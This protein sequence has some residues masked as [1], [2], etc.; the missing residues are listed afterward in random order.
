M[1]RKHKTVNRAKYQRTG[2][3]KEAA[4]RGKDD[5]YSEKQWQHRLRCQN[6]SI[7]SWSAVHS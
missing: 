5:A 2:I 6:W 7:A 3:E 4:D 1:I